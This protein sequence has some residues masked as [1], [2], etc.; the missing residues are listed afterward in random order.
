MT[1][2]KRRR[3]KVDPFFDQ[4]GEVPDTE[5]AK[6]AG[7]TPENVRAY[8]KRRGIPARWRGKGQSKG[9]PTSVPRGPSSA[10]ASKRRKTKLEP[11]LDQ[12]G[13][14]PDAECQTAPHLDPPVSTLLR[15]PLHL[16]VAATVSLGLS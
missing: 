4:L 15:P 10:R 6:L 11:F 14:L 16:Q 13:V 12:L 2:R 5:I 1:T 3:S 9:K 8:R 7:V